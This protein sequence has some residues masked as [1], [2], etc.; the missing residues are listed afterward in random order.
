M[1]DAQANLEK[2]QAEANQA[3]S[4]QS[5]NIQLSSAGLIAGSALE[6]GGSAK[7]VADATVRSARV[8]LDRAKQNLSFTS[9]YA[10]IDGVV[11]ERNVNLGQTV[12]ASLSAPQLF[13]IANDLS[14]MRILALVERATSCG[15]ARDRP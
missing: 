4:D 11:V 1:A 6:Q 15:S 5:R 2:V 8:A 12:A 7:Q 9:I 3:R 14:R 10:P 13:L